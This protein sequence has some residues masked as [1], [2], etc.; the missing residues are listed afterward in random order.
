MKDI[1]EK[2]KSL[3]CDSLLG[4]ITLYNVNNNIIIM[5]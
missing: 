2:T 3:K 4:Q 1:L 5:M